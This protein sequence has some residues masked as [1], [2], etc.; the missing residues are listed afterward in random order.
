MK[1]CP[2]LYYYD[3]ADNK[4]IRLT[5]GLLVYFRKRVVFVSNEKKYDNIIA[6][7][8]WEDQD[9]YNSSLKKTFPQYKYFW[10]LVSKEIDESWF[11]RLVA[12]PD[13]TLPELNKICGIYW[14]DE[15]TEKLITQNKK[16]KE[17]NL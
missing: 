6:N 9:D 13:K 14:G 5:A 1:V 16:F 12:N 15:I 4:I 11:N 2:C 17:I 7:Y 8:D 10:I 3:E